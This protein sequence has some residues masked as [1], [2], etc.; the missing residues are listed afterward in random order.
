MAVKGV[1]FD[2]TE[3]LLTGRSSA[4]TPVAGIPQAI[5]R[6]H[7][8][9]VQ[10]IA[11]G[12]HPH[13]SLARA[14][15]KAGLYCDLVVG[16]DDVGKNKGSPL[17]VQHICSSTSLKANELLYI[18]DSDQDMITAVQGRV[19]YA[20]AAWGN[21][22]TYRYGLDA[23]A[24][25]WVPTVV[26]LIFQKQQ[27]W[28]W[29]VNTHDALRRVATARAMTD[30]LDHLA[31]RDPLLNVFKGERDFTI[32][33]SSM[34]FRDFIM[35]N[36]LASLYH[37]DTFSNVDLWTTYPGSTGKPNTIMGEFLAVAA[38]LFRQQYRSDLFIRHRRAQ[39]SAEA[40][41]KHLNPMDAAFNQFDTVQINPI[42]RQLLRDKRVLIL[43]DFMTRGITTECGRNM[44]LSAGAGGVVIAAIAKYPSDF[45]VITVQDQTWD[46]FSVGALSHAGVKIR[47]ESGERNAS[48]LDE[49]RSSYQRMAAASW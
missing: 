40:Y 4:I 20:H 18:G 31:L 35:L 36:L 46:P 15:Q 23:P 12:N 28:Y 32:G 21:A 41:K 13:A 19:I 6:L 38:L 37:E 47:W 24:P 48:A 26:E 10:V 39:H 16:H 22:K 14:L 2:V 7:A 1:I 30:A 29:S 11:A 8:L 49:I 5:D 45:H 44:L 3:T 33:N 34:G 17:W 42:H 43:D 25:G 27:P 9:D